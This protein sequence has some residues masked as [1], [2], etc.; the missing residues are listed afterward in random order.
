MSEAFL[1][2][3]AEAVEQPAATGHHARDRSCSLQVEGRLGRQSAVSGHRSLLGE[4]G[5]R[6]P[7]APGAVAA[8]AIY[9]ATGGCSVAL[10]PTLCVGLAMVPS[11]PSK[12]GGW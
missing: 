9:H 5:L 8:Q 10:R 3:E 2:V 11:L 7:A 12:L 6:T 4:N 1:A